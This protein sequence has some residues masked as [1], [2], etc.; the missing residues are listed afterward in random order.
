MRRS[1]RVFSAPLKGL[2]FGFGQ[3]LSISLL[4]SETLPN[5]DIMHADVATFHILP[6]VACGIHSCGINAANVFITSIYLQ[7]VLDQ[8]L[9]AR[10]AA[11][12]SPGHFCSNAVA[13]LGIAWC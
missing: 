11:S 5:R 6:K 8:A 1:S 9:A 4:F 10:D 13:S 12:D 7:P 3:T 2:A